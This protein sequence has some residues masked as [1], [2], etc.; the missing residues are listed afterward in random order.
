M[1]TPITMHYP[2]C[3]ILELNP[4][5]RVG[6]FVPTRKILFSIHGIKMEQFCNAL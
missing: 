5:I 1:N 6:I 3:F 2:C 4:G